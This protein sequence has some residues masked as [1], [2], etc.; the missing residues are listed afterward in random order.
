MLTARAPGELP[1]KRIARLMESM[2][3]NGG[4]L[5]RIWA[6]LGARHGDNNQVLAL[7]EAL[8]IPFEIKPLSYNLWRHLQPPLLGATFRSVARAS[9]DLVADDWPDLTISAGHRSVPVVQAI[10]KA[11]MGRT[12]AVHVGYPRISPEKFDLVVAT[13]EYPIADHPNLLRI[14]FALTRASDQPTADRDLRRTFPRPR[15]LLVLGGPTLYWRLRRTDVLQALGSLL[16]RA[17]FEGGSVMVVGSPRTPKHLLAQ[18]QD[19]IGHA[20]VPTALI[21]LQGPPSYGSLLAEADSIAVTADSVAMI[22]DAIMTG[23]PVGVVP[24]RSTFFG[25]FTMGIMAQVRPGRRVHPRDLR[26]FW[27]ALEKGHL[28]GTIHRPVCGDVPDLIGMVSERVKAILGRD[29]F[30]PGRL[31][32]QSQTAIAHASSE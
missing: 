1:G 30:V 28:V 17:G 20:I 12:R 25:W 32:A 8:G 2:A 7:A 23:K 6:L 24:V 19:R 10:R 31:S 9:R 21:P 16:E 11:S 4:R 14:P 18:V 15:R 13:P 3:G 27:K 26:F 29:P 5:L 22:S